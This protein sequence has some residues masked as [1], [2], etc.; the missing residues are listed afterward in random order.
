MNK[1]NDTTIKGNFDD[2]EE[3]LLKEGDANHFLSY[4][5]DSNVLLIENIGQN[6]E[7]IKLEYPESTVMKIY[8]DFEDFEVDYDE[9]VATLLNRVRELHKSKEK[10]QKR[11]SQLPS[12]L[13][14][15]ME[16]LDNLDCEDVDDIELDIE[17][18]DKRESS[19][20]ENYNF[21]DESTIDEE[22]KTVPEEMPLVKRSNRKSFKI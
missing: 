7:S 2:I 5:N 17:M 19:N 3:H 22:V 18:L 9:K 6:K 8:V 10:Y 15:V 13:N 11:A 14:R 12:E 4:T 16:G 21:D 20:I 1:I